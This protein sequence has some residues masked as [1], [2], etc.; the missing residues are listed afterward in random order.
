[1]PGCSNSMYNSRARVEVLE[2]DCL[3]IFSHL[4]HI[5]FL[6]PVS[7]RLKYYFV[8]IEINCLC[9]CKELCESSV[10]TRIPPK[11]MSRL[12]RNMCQ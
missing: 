12:G 9:A 4:C 8:S 2:G 5:F 10:Y 1:M 6:S 3:D 11:A 7:D